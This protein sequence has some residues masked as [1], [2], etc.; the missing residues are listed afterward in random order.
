ML[1]K[2]CVISFSTQMGAFTDE[3]EIVVLKCKIY[4]KSDQQ[5]KMTFWTK[6]KIKCY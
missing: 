4:S 6:T 5:N 2:T 3:P 1:E